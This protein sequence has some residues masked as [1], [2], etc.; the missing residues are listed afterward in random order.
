M[1]EQA[2]Q[3]PAPEALE[4]ERAEAIPWGSAEQ[5]CFAHSHSPRGKG[6]GEQAPPCTTGSAPHKGSGAG[7]RKP[8]ALLHISSPAISTPRR[9]GP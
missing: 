3:E 9:P 4:G 2:G 5:G 1:S 6:R 8:S 7:A